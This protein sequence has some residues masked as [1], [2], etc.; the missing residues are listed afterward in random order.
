V[1]KI[2]AIVGSITLALVAAV[3]LALLW[4]AP[5]GRRLDASSRD[6]ASHL[7]DTTL[8]TWDLEGIKSE[9]SEQFLGA[10]PDEKLARLLST[11]AKRLGAIQSHGDPRGESRLSVWNFHKVIT[12][13]YVVPVTF[14]KAGGTI[15]LRFILD[16]DQ[17]RLL[18]L[19]VNSDALLQ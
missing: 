8:K 11:F 7:L 1:R 9:A 10:V 6:Y 3:A 19:N 4:Y 15:A 16:G 2:L 18:M 14:E 17:W 5:E 13:D 12:A